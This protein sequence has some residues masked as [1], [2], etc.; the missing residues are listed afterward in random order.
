MKS[1]TSTPKHTDPIL[2][3]VL[4]GLVVAVSILALVVYGLWS[5]AD[6]W[7]RPGVNAWAIA[8]TL[9]LVPAFLSGFWFGKT[10]VRGFLSGA[11]HMLDRMAGIVQQVAT[12]REATRTAP[13]PAGQ[14]PAPPLWQVNPPPPLQITYRSGGP[15]APDDL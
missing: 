13:R 9:L 15:D 14:P 6:A 7:T 3:L 2:T 5:L 1:F 8:A 11:D 4:L 10:E 12:V